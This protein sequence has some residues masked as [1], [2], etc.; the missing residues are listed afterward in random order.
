MKLFLTLLCLVAGLPQ[1]SHAAT[2]M[3]A[4][5]SSTTPVAG[6]SPLGPDYAPVYE[7]SQ[8]TRRTVGGTETVDLDL[9]PGDVV[10]A[11]GHLQ[12]TEENCALS[13]PD[14]VAAPVYALLSYRIGPAGT[15]TRFSPYVRQH[16]IRRENHHMPLN[17]AGMLEV[18]T[19]GRYRFSLQAR[20][21]AVAQTV[22]VEDQI[23]DGHLSL[24]IFRVTAQPDANSRALAQMG[25]NGALGTNL[26]IEPCPGCSWSE[27]AQVGAEVGMNAQSGDL[28]QVHGQ[29]AALYNTTNT[30]AGHMLVVETQAGDWTR[31]SW[32]APRENV[33][34]VLVKLSLFGMLSYTNDAGT[35]PVRARSLA[36]ALG[37]AV[38]SGYFVQAFTNRVSMLRFSAD[39]RLFP[40]FAA[41]QQSSQDVDYDVNPSGP[42]PWVVSHSQVLQGRQNGL[43]NGDVVRAEGAMGLQF[44]AATGASLR[45][46][47]RLYLVEG[48][49][50]AYAPGQ[51]VNIETLPSRGFSA[52]TLREVSGQLPSVSLPTF[53][54]IEVD[55]PIRGRA[56]ATVIHVLNCDKTDAPPLRTPAGFSGLIT[57]VFR[58]SIFMDGFDPD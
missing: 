2:W 15:T 48:T 47:T 24:E 42:T 35:L 31:R 58:D 27:F 5:A 44:T 49:S 50:A 46:R 8:V 38:G 53:A 36:Y 22:V 56:D 14:C 51:E 55:W 4:S 20:Q 16:V 6:S 17:V 26:L 7:I 11:Y 33:T 10:R 12:V 23:Y 39:G 41:A 34:D 37:D 1:A 19:A 28:L 45:C 52:I 30:M 43:R 29:F 21:T 40:A 13:V 9:L 25:R 54:A 18:N 3:W 57:E 32:L